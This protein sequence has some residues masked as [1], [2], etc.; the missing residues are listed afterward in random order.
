MR[1]ATSLSVPVCLVKT[2]PDGACLHCVQLHNSANWMAFLNGLRVVFLLAVAGLTELAEW[3]AGLDFDADEL[4]LLIVAHVSCRF[5]PV[6]GPLVFGQMP[7]S[8][9]TFGL[10]GHR[11]ILATISSTLAMLRGYH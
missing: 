3:D 10:L 2:E 7:V 6:K 1:S 8:M 4:Q 5:A 9:G 11:F